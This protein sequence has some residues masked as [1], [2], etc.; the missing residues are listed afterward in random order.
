MGCRLSRICGGE[1]DALADVAADKRGDAFNGGAHLLGSLEDPLCRR[2][3]KLLGGVLGGQGFDERQP[4][5]LLTQL[6]DGFVDAAR[7]HEV[8]VTAGPGFGHDRLVVH[9]RKA[10]LQSL[11]GKGFDGGAETRLIA[12]LTGLV[13]GPGCGLRVDGRGNGTLQQRQRHHGGG[14][15]PRGSSAL[16]T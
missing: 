6:I 13:V 8:D 14:D 3:G 11:D 2:C 9:A 5:G 16:A 4:A 1:L 7:H 12:R 10:L 15:A